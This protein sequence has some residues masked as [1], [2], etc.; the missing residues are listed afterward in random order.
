M[1]EHVALTPMPT[2]VD[3]LHDD[4]DAYNYG[5][6]DHDDCGPVYESFH[7]DDWSIQSL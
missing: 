7:C 3:N 4:H 2:L 5:D 1:A 6:F